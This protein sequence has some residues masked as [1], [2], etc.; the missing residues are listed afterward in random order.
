[1]T[2]R[3]SLLPLRVLNLLASVAVV[4]VVLTALVGYA[5]SGPAIVVGLLAGVGAFLFTNRRTSQRIAAAV[6][7]VERHL[8][9]GRTDRA[10]SILRAQRRL[11]RRQFGLGRALDGQIGMLLYAHARDHAAARPYLERAPRRLW[12][13]QVMLGADRFRARDYGAM[14]RAFG[15]ALRH[16]GDQGIV[17]SAYAW[18]QLRRGRRKAAIDLLHSGRARVPDDRALARNLRA[19]LE[20][21]NLPMYAY[22]DAWWALGLERPRAAA[23][24]VAPGARRARRSRAA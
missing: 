20:H 24:R 2:P 5:G 11:G 8:V 17:W 4:A 13:A 1:L 7:E 16:G 18:C 9:A 14:E 6:P 10:L 23:H 15:R 12:P 21:K 3:R 19:A 22:G